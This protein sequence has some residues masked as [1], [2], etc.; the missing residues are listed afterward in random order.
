MGS[1]WA[2]QSSASV[3]SGF[4]VRAISTFHS[5]ANLPGHH[6]EHVKTGILPFESPDPFTSKKNA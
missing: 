4:T 3:V 6:S 2:I 1:R 5:P